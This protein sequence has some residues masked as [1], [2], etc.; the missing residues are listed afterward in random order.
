V[1]VI[2]YQPYEAV[3]SSSPS[4]TLVMHLLPLPG[5]EAGAAFS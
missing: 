2:L 3:K 4:S 5:A 1:L